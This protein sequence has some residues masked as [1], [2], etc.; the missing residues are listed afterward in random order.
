MAN[1]VPLIIPPKTPVPMECWVLSLAPVASINGTT[2][3]VKASE[4]IIIGRNRCRDAS[5]IAEKISMPC[6]RSCLANSII[7]MAFLVES[8]MIV[9]IPTLKN[10]SFDMS[11]MKTAQTA[12][13]S[14]NGTTNITAKGVAQLS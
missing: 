9:I 13:I 6:I 7:K 11:A 1:N 4:V 5:N 2:P 14:P 8:P 12:P 3:S 10:T